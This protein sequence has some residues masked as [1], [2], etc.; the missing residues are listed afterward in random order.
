[1]TLNDFADVGSVVGIFFVAVGLLLSIQQFKFSRTM[2]YMK[3]LCDPSVIDTRAKVD[4]WL[5]SSDDDNI[6]LQA[7][8]DDHNLHAHV[9]AFLSF[10]NQVSIAYR[11]GTLHNK[12]AFDIWFPL[13]PSYWDSLHFYI[14]WRR[15]NGYPVGHNFEDFAKDI[16]AFQNNKISGM[17]R[18]RKVA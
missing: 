7:L 9:K 2:D 1:M 6:R 4:A 8:E 16:R 14:L 15:A 12:M 11:F 18:K 3:H 13:I 10:C 5:A 17:S